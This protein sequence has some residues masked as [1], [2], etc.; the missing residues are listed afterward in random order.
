MA[1]CAHCKTQD[2]DLYEYNVPIC[3]QCAKL[4]EAKAKEPATGQDIRSILTRGVTE[5]TASAN[6]A[7]L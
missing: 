1:A 6:S 2:T 3:L 4:R 7:A 5:A